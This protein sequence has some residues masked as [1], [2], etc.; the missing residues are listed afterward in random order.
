M[1]AILALLVL[2]YV[3]LLVP[4]I[5]ATAMLAAALFGLVAVER[6]WPTFSTRGADRVRS[7]AGA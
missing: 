3:S 1:G 2:L 5:V 4:G 7:D 6:R